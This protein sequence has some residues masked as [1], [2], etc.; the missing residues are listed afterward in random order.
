[1]L[2]ATLEGPY[3]AIYRSLKK[4]K[5]KTKTPQCKV[6]SPPF[7]EIKHTLQDFTQASHPVN[8]Y[9]K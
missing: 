5:M 3:S 2:P 6:Y 4:N 1:M 9:D 7:T 8:I